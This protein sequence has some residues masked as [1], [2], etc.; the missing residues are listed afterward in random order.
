MKS[1]RCRLGSDIQ[2]VND[3]AT[4]RC[5]KIYLLLE[6]RY[7]YFS[8]KRLSDSAEAEFAIWVRTA[9]WNPGE[10]NLRL[11]DEFFLENQRNLPRQQQITAI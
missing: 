11:R 2:I 10:I 5:M 1:D 3:S 8:S 4:E 6:R 9:N 7:A